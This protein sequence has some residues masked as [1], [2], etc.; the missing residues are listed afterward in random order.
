MRSSQRLELEKEQQAAL[1]RAAT[2]RSWCGLSVAVSISSEVALY[3]DD[4]ELA[5][6]IRIVE[7]SPDAALRA[8]QAR[9]KQPAMLQ[10]NWKL[11]AQSVPG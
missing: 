10:T 11:G 7:Q 6:R 5:C 3:A 1:S 2:T 8:Q 4:L 9:Q